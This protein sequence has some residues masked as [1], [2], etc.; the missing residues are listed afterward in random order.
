MVVI[1]IGWVRRALWRE[2][3][4]KK[5]AKPAFSRKEGTRR[6]KA[7]EQIT[8]FFFASSDDIR[9]TVAHM[10]KTHKQNAA[11]KKITTNSTATHSLLRFER[12][13]MSLPGPGPASRCRK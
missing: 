9:W 6:Q 8:A 11:E 12:Q 4:K 7:G 5:E 13:N 1:V 10:Q 2:A 3:E